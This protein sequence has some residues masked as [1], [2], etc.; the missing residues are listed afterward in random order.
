MA[1]AINAQCALSCTVQSAAPP[2]HN[3]CKHHKAPQPCAQPVLTETQ[4]PQYIAAPTV[5]VF[6]VTLRQSFYTSPPYHQPD[7]LPDLQF[8][9]ILRI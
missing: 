1:V 9:A 5:T 6:E 7:I 2:A 8:F 3:C 4:T